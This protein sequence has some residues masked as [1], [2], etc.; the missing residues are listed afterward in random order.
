MTLTS[1]SQS[2]TTSYARDSDG[3]LTTYGPFTVRRTGPSG[4]A[5][6]YTAGEIEHGVARDDHGRP[7]TL[8]DSVNGTVRYRAAVGYDGDDHVSARS[9]TVNGVTH[10]YVYAY[11]GSGQLT[12]VSV[13][14]PSPRPTCRR[15]RQPHGSPAGSAGYD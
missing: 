14:E 7:A 3:L 9:E 13:T 11:D 12:Q 15:Q 2:V 1:G 8:T 4:A 6:R 5:D 10:A